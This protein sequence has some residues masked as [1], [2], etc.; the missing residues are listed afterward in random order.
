MIATRRSLLKMGL[1]TLFVPSAQFALA[2][3]KQK[4]SFHD[5]RSDFEAIVQD[6]MRAAKVVGAAVAVTSRNNPTYYT[7]AFGFADLKN[8]RKLTADTPMHLASVS[9]L[10]TVSALVQLFERKRLD[11]HRDVNDFIDFK[12]RNPRHPNVPI[13]VHQLV[14]HTS[15]ISD[16]GYG[17]VSFPGDPTQSLPDFLKGY[18]VKGGAAYSPQSFLK[19]KPGAKWDYS[20]VAMALAG[21]VVQSVGKQSF[22]S[23][24]EDNVLVPLGIHN[25]HWHL[26][27]FAPDVLAKPYRFENGDFVELPQQGYPD[28]PAGMLRCSVSDLAKSLHAM[29]GQERGSKAIL[30]PAAVRAMLRRQ[31][32]RKITLYQGL[33]WLEEETK[34]QK[35]IGH[36]GSDNG[37]L[38]MVALTKDR[39]QAV[40]LLINTDGTDEVR[41]FRASVVD[42]LLAGA[43]LAR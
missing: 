43:K 42:D 31:V 3:A 26:R 13:T 33:C 18:L 10:F 9:K 28:V 22:P 5:W 32:S 37:A 36:T 29:V 23:Y 24:V 7:A 8:Q 6:R 12:V 25:G 41:K 40:A 30:S 17:D 2:D 27:D 34:T 35:V 21:Y 1:A 38:N 19:A 11:L 20:N 14:T 15:S 16:A 4:R 39:K